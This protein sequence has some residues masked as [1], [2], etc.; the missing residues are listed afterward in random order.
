VGEGLATVVLCALV[1]GSTDFV[2]ARAVWDAIWGHERAWLPTN[3]RTLDSPEGPVLGEAL[4]SL[5]LLLT[6]LLTVPALLWLP[7]AYFFGG[8]FLFSPAILRVYDDHAGHRPWKPLRLRPVAA[9]VLAAFL[10]TSLWV[11][12]APPPVSTA[13]HAVEVRGKALLVDGR[14]FEVKGVHYGPWRPGTGP[15]KGY[16]YP[17]ADL[18]SQDLSLI[19][20]L[21]ANTIVVVDPPDY[22]LDLAERYSLKVIYAFYLDWWAFG[23][24]EAE[25]AANAVVGRVAEL[26]H[27]PAL[28]GWMLGNEIPVAAF[29]QRGTAPFE[30]GLQNLYQRVKAVDP[31]HPVT[32]ANWPLAKQ[33]HLE[34]LD[35]AS[36]NLY[37]L[38]P[39]EVVVMGYEN[40]LR[41]VLQPVAG[42]RPLLITEFG[43]NTIEVGEQGQAR[44]LRTNWEGIRRGGAVGGVVFEFADEWW[45]N[46]DNPR[47]AGNWWDRVPA[48]DDELH[49]DQDPEES[50]GLLTAD[51][52]PKPAYAVLREAFAPAAGLDGR[53]V[54]AL[55]VAV[56]V[57][58]AAGLWVWA[59]LAVQPAALPSPANGLELATQAELEEP[60]R[61]H[62]RMLE[63]CAC[64]PS[65]TGSLSL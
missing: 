41:D 31:T 52:Q 46:Y 49:H 29:E 48:T 13:P 59:R 32:H 53:V 3:Q 65:T 60:D 44:L 47:G 62:I 24:A 36:F 11:A 40:Y 9:I 61:T 51:R 21:H 64:G 26:R 30:R 4:F 8:K 55:V 37:P 5:L 27:K 7:S 54:P 35:I 15:T 16:P 50:Y 10:A 18:V 20:D 2:V 19:R 33:L 63:S 38:W 28:L 57:T 42:E 1:Y 14:P 22:V 43:V 12:V 45:K 39:P 25:Q 23:T 58:V 6:P 17:A 56:L 34:F